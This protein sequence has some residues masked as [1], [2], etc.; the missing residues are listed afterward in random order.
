MKNWE[1]TTF[2]DHW[3]PQCQQG[4]QQSPIALSEEA[5]DITTYDPL[6][7]INYDLPFAV[8]LKNNG[9]SGN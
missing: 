5:S 6:T 3:A 1:R 4:K 2:P 8:Y 7:F 9:H